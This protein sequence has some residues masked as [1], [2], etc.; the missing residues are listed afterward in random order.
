VL[1]EGLVAQF[2]SAA[3]ML[4]RDMDLRRWRNGAEL[5]M[6]GANALVLGDVPGR[7]IRI[8]V[9]GPGNTPRALLSC[10]RLH[11]RTINAGLTSPGEF[12][13][14]PWLDAEPVDYA[15]LLA[16]ESADRPFIQVKDRR[17]PQL[18]GV[19]M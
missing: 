19:P 6:D 16:W 5:R 8:L 9:Q 12:V 7:Y 14:V 10:I 13:P 15:D 18:Y 17:R 1:P 3:H 4:G 11:F 2:I